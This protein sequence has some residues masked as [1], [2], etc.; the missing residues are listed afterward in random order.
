MARR[1][2]TLARTR[3]IAALVMSVVVVVGTALGW[4]LIRRLEFST[5]ASYACKMLASLMINYVCR[6][7]L[8]FK[9]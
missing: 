1:H 2:R 8:V 5:T 7:F 4:F 6:K 9:R 3:V